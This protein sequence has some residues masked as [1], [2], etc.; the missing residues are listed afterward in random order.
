M[1]VDSLIAALVLFAACIGGWHMAVS[2]K[3]SVRLPL[4]FA[5]VLLAAL[6]VAAALRIGDMAALLLLPLS[7]A[8][9]ALAALARFARPVAQL[10]ATLALVLAL[11][12]GLGALV[13]GYAMPG[14]VLTLLAGLCIIAAALNALAMPA[15]LS[16]VA[17]VAGGLCFLQA[18]IGA[19]ALLFAAAA[20]LGIAKSQSVRS[21]RRAMRG[22]VLP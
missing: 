14:L 10:P 5:A 9:L 15:M 1:A 16:G 3:A 8:A 22:A 18:G 2:L 13:S 4:R 21:T 7:S 6:A 12:A 20:L 11:A 19:G 17:V